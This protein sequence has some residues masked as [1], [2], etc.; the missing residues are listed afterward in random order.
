MSKARLIITAVV[1]E[2]RSQREVARA[3]GT[4]QSWVSRLV[5]RYRA[6]GEAAFEPRSRRPKTSPTA[7]PP[8]T[9][10]LITELRGKL[11]AAGLDAGPDTI[12][13]HLA[14]HH[15]THVSV[16]S[17]SR[18]LTRL[19][20]VTSQP[21]KRPKASYQRFQAELAN[22]CWQADFIHYPLAGPPTAPASDAEV[23]IWLDDHSRDALD[24]TAHQPVTGPIVRDRRG[25]PLRR[26]G[27]DLDRQRDG[28]HHALCWRP[29]RLGGRAA[30]PQGRAEEQPP[31]QAHDLWQGRA[32]PADAEEG[33]LGI[34]ELVAV[35]VAVESGGGLPPGPAAPAGVG[36]VAEE[37]GEP[38]G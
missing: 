38:G 10:T 12:A 25:G 35:A 15:G 18:Y 32:V 13:W 16:A 4:N 9:V 23:L 31:E 5:A 1:I 6:E 2:G 34:A 26:S 7:I 30:P 36:D 22:Q 29:Q 3:Y 14:H 17:I 33:S 19:G 37:A 20:L 11:T 28:L 21:T 24:V 8:A 27:L